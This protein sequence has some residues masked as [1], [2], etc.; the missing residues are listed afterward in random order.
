MAKRKI[1]SITP[2]AARLLFAAE[3]WVDSR[4]GFTIAKSRYIRK[5][6]SP[7]LELVG[8]QS[9]AGD[10]RC[11]KISDKGMLG[12]RAMIVKLVVL[13]GIDEVEGQRPACALGQLN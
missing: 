7:S 3:A 6:L 2:L 8:K 4:G 5:M 11:Q 13:N 10:F 9:Q 1:T 12:S